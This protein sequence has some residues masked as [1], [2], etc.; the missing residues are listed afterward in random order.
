MAEQKRKVNILFIEDDNLLR[1]L[2]TELFN[3]DQ[4]YEYESASAVDLKSARE[5]LEGLKPSAIVLD[6][7]LPYDKSSPDKPEVSED[8]GFSF[9]AEI[10]QRP[11]FKDIPVIV[12][13]NLNEVE[14]KE[15]AKSLGA[16]AY[17]IKSVTTPDKFMEV[18]KKA[19]SG[20]AF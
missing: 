18:L 19:L 3:I 20:Q 7:I 11:N 13:S 5:T 17:L 10:K 9:L 16:Y 2:F 15:R 4:D 8:M 12:F 6:L 14:A 1:T